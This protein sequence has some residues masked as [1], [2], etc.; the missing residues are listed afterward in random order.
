[1]NSKQLIVNIIRREFDMASESYRHAHA[2]RVGIDAAANAWDD[3]NKNDGIGGFSTNPHNTTLAA[4][5]EHTA[6][7]HYENMREAY[8]C[9]VD[10]FIADVQTDD[11]ITE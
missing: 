8:S 10:T 11:Q 6:K 1:M 9:A 7:V 5:R 4:I 3:F 2:E